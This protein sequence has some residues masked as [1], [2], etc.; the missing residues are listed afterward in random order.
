[1]TSFEI[2][3]VSPTLARSLLRGMQF[4]AMSIQ[5]QLKRGTAM[6]L[7][8]N[9]N[10]TIAL[11]ATVLVG[12]V[13][14]SVA[15]A[16]NTSNS[17]V[18]AIKTRQQG[19]KDLGAAFKLVRDQVKTDSPDTDKIKVAAVNVKKV[20]DEIATWFPQGSGPEAGVKTAA[21]PE[22]WSNADGFTAARNKFIEQADKFVQAANSGDVNAIGGQTKALGEAC[23]ACHDKFRVKE[24]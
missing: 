17:P 2:E 6:M 15:I 7:K 22:I 20:A 1:M 8:S 24:S 21:K 3:V 23:G 16:A 10:F 13:G 12:A 9:R 11:A 14:A 19:L 4:K 5:A 18:D